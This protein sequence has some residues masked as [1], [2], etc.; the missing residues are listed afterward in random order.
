MSKALKSA[1]KRW[2]AD[3][4]ALL[5]SMSN[6]RKIALLNVLAG[7]LRCG[8]WEALER[9][10]KL[11]EDEL[12]ELREGIAN[13]DIHELRDGIADLLVTTY[14]L[15]HIAGVDAD[16]DLHEVVLS[17]LSKFD[18]DNTDAAQRTREKYLALG[19]ETTQQQ[20]PDPLDPNRRLV[21]TRS[22]YTQT[23]IDQKQ[24]PGG[25]WLK[26]ADFVEPEFTPLPPDAQK[27]LSPT[28]TETVL[29]D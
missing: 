15:A 10:L 20:R 29:V 21:V 18:S 23:G 25:K 24:Y 3:K 9:Q 17:N 16:E 22:A 7:N 11:I 27:A 12:K 1:S 26:S 2:S 19:V 8:G 6:F 14:G 4:L 13:K 5:Q 28:G